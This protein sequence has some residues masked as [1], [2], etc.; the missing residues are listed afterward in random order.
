VACAGYRVHAISAEGTELWLRSPAG[1]AA[2]DPALADFDGDDHDEIVLVRRGPSALAI[3]AST[4]ASFSTTWPIDLPSLGWGSPVVGRMVAGGLPGIGQYIYGEGVHVFDLS[5]R[6]VAG[7]PKRGRAGDSP[8]IADLDG[9]GRAEIVVGS[10][11]DTGRDSIVYIYDAGAG[12]WDEGPPLWPTGRGNYARTGSRFYSPAIGTVDN[13]PPA[14]IADLRVVESVG[15]SVAL[16]WT[17]TGDDGTQGRPRTYLMRASEQPIDQASFDLAEVA[18]D[19]AAVSDAGRA[20][21]STLTGVLRGHRY[22]IAVEAVDEGGNRSGISNVIAVRIGPLAGTTG[23]ALAASE[24]PAR[25]PVTLHWQAGGTGGVQEIRLFDVAGRLERRF[26]L[27]AGTEGVVV[28]D[29]RDGEGDVL[30]AG[31]YFARLASGTTTTVAK[32]VLLR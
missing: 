22:W 1:V 14:A 6:L 27:G 9:D 3:L 17:A 19:V 10:A 24:S 16:A 32:I 20:E 30:P 18:A 21:S 28:W 23:T 26:D 2:G 5:G 8:S 29:G 15:S 12:T 25:L 31:V 7:F 13:Q 11:R 4:G